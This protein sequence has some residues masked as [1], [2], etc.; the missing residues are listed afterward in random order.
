M[1]VLAWPGTAFY[2][3]LLFLVYLVWIT[4]AFL[5]TVVGATCWSRGFTVNSRVFLVQ[6]ILT[7]DDCIWHVI[8]LFN[9][10]FLSSSQNC[11][12]QVRLQKLTTVCWAVNISQLKMLHSCICVFLGCGEL[13]LAGFMF[14][15]SCCVT[16]MIKNLCWPLYHPRC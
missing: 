12:L 5:E 1:V 15:C 7:S 13:L 4:P 3:Q 16:K 8:V 10:L 14:V 9:F 6:G 11:L 2:V